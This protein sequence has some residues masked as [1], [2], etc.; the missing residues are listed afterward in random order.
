MRALKA[1]SQNFSQAPA[2]QVVPPAGT[3]TTHPLH[4][5][6]SSAAPTQAREKIRESTLNAKT[7]KPNPVQRNTLQ[8]TR[9]QPS[10]DAVNTAPIQ[11][12]PGTAEQVELYNSIEQRRSKANGEKPVAKRSMY[13]RQPN[14]RRLSFHDERELTGGQDIGD[15]G[16]SRRQK[17]RNHVEVEEEEEEN[18]FGQDTRPEDPQRKKR[19][20]ATPPP[21]AQQQARAG[22]P[23]VEPAPRPARHRPLPTEIAPQRERQASVERPQ[24]ANRR[25]RQASVEPQGAVPRRNRHLL[26]VSNVIPGLENGYGDLRERIKHAGARRRLQM[27]GKPTQT[28]NK[29][30]D[31]EETKLIEMVGLFGCRWSLID[32]MASAVLGHRGQV[33]L[34]DKAR[35]IKFSLLK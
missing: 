15:I 31:V 20:R 34:K 19:S 23:I 17:K 33:A 4:P 21:P 3:V 14:A 6:E 30:T 9:D 24:P 29:W 5:S 22:R 16:P 10:F 35:N 13:D 32:S 8:D 1:I 25:N 2:A 26:E 7:S 12:P 27:I 11:I 28:R 18:P